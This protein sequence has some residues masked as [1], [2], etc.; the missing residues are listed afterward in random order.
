M[1][2]ALT[3]TRPLLRTSV[4]HDGRLMAPWI[5]FTTALSASSVLAY[6]WVFPTQHDRVGLAAAVGSNPALGLIFGPAYN[7]STADGFDA[8]RSLALGGFLAALGMIFATRF[9]IQTV[10]FCVFL[11]RLNPCFLFRIHGHRSS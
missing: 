3:G 8:W 5:L 4:K 7:L 6:G 10:L 1:S 11:H 9:F 2:T